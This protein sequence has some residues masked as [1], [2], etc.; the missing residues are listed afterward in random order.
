MIASAPGLVRIG[1]RPDLSFGHTAA[2]NDRAPWAR[3]VLLFTSGKG[4]VGK[5]TVAVNVAVALARRGLRVGLLDADVFGPSVPRMVSLEDER[6]RW[7][8]AGKMVPAE[9]FGLRVMSVG[10]TTPESDT[11]LVWRSAVA[12]AALVQLLED[13]AWGPLDVLAV[14]LP[15]GTGDVQL[16]LAQELRVAGAVVVTTPQTVATDDVRRAIRMLQESRVPVAGV[17]ENMSA[18]VAP[19]TGAVYH[20]FGQGGGR[21]LAED[22]GVPFLG[23]IPLDA[24]IRAAADEGTPIA[25]VGEPA[26]RAVFEELAARLVAAVEEREKDHTGVPRDAGRKDTP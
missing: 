21:M 6:V 18:F 25:A 19:D 9:N 23:E 16:T 24:R 13:V 5:S 10:L 11:P 7:D 17:V 4:G 14:D 26:Q 15:P 22:Y 1:S 12:T 8:E 20:P 3:R 2:P